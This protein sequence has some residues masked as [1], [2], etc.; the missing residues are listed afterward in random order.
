MHARTHTRTCPFSYAAAMADLSGEAVHLVPFKENDKDP[1]VRF[2]T[3]TPETLP[4]MEV[5]F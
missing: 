3:A 1:R 4:H 5:F 2:V